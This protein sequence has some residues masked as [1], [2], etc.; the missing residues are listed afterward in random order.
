MGVKGH[1]RFWLQGLLTGQDILG[2]I[3]PL[4]FGLQPLLIL[5]G[6]QGVDV[7]I[8]PAALDRET[9]PE[10]GEAAGHDLFQGGELSLP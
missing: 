9:L 1:R 3:G 10:A 8:R 4:G 7:Q 2:L 6:L 5:L